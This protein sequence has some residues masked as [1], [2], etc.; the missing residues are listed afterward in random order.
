[1]SE[2][3]LR[4]IGRR[5]FLGVAGKVMFATGAAAVVGTSAAGQPI[6]DYS[7]PKGGRACCDT[8]DGQN[9][10]IFSHNT[11]TGTHTCKGENGNVCGGGFTNRCETKNECS[12][13]A[14]ANKCTK[15]TQGGNI[16]Q[17]VH[18][19][20]SNDAVGVNN[21]QVGT[22]ANRCI[23]KNWCYKVT[24]GESNV[25]N[26]IAANVCD[27]YETVEEKEPKPKK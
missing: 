25:C 2:D 13:A 24:G 3:R 27:N 17:E 16:C 18:N 20:C 15:V 22:A 7:N 10:C 23:E 19:K 14:S 6:G 26:P 8:T 1:M 4:R 12:G 21:C 11:C 9:K 5:D